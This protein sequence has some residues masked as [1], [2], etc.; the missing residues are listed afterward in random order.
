MGGLEITVL[1][2]A[3]VLAGALLA[4]RLRIAT[5]LVFVLLGLLL[6]FV[7]SLR[8]IELPPET[9]LLLFLPVM[10]FW[11]SLTTSLRS[12]R[13][14]LRGIVLMSTL[15]VVLTAFAVAGVAHLLG[16]PWEAALILGAA[17]APP[18]ATAVAA[19]GRSLPRRNF[20][21]LKAESLTND[22]TALVVYAIA[23]GL[24]TGGSYTPWTITGMVALSYLGG[25]A[26]GIVTAIAAY[27]LMSRLRSALTIN[28]ALLL[29]PFAAFLAAEI[30]HASGVLAVVVAGLISAYLG[31]RIST[32][33]SRRQRD[34]VWPLGAFL[35]NGALFVLI[36]IE[37]QAVIRTIDLRDV[38]WLLL[39]TLAAWGVLL[40]VRF[41]FLWAS[42]MLIRLLDRRPSQRLRRMSN[43]AR[44][45]STVAGFRGAVSLAIALS[46]PLGEG[47][48]AVDGRN[49]VIFVTA[50]VILLT[51][52][53]QGPLLPAV[54]RWARLPADTAAEEELQL[55]ER[56]ITGA[57][58]ARIEEIAADVGISDEVRERLTRDY[59]EALELANARV[60]ARVDREIEALDAMIDTRDPDA[61]AE[62]E[63]QGA[64]V[65][66]GTAV[67][68]PLAR[69]EEYTRLR[70]AVLDSK[71]EV[72]VRLTRDGAVD[73][74]VARRI[75]TRLDVEEVRL[76]GPESLE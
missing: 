20:T 60:Q 1:L 30:I 52:L 24:A 32:A 21:L 2:G 64:V 72:L 10:L 41:G 29:T 69:N 68:S 16:V 54:V 12:I 66:V 38:G 5:P 58:L 45:V 50:G 23:V 73:D 11:E 27:L 62:G 25:I 35:L 14:D 39:V 13:R 47:A 67:V 57:A 48:G 3:S 22:G 63:L 46:I 51:L 43:R 18:D 9:V 59:Y 28:I 34:A 33:A 65:A 15:L 4:P 6:G 74:D 37:V 53:V 44:A 71:R 40:V 42:A 19:L 31:P 49:E 70:L 61:D 17:V 55:A 26:A 56:S 36:G 8:G 76:R 7:P 75:H